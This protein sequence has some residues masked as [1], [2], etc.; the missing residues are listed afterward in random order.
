[1]KIFFIILS[2]FLIQSCN[3]PKTVLICGN[4]VCVN[5][6]EAEQYFEEN[7]SIEVR[8]I[9]KKEIN[10]TDLVELNLQKQSNDKRKIS[11]IS[12][13]QTNKEV[14]VL[15][16]NEIK[17]I[18]K[19]IKYKKKTKKITKKVPI[20][21]KTNVKRRINKEVVDVC[22]IIEKCSIDNIT[23]Y[24]LDQGRKKKFPDITTRE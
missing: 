10:K 1:M 17:K 21:I 5:K 16:K 12:K 20:N 14:K 2:A 18:K 19:N 8:L 6:A 22:T 23:K 11:I 9:D 7:L 15:S 24:L 4:H 13:K 3:K